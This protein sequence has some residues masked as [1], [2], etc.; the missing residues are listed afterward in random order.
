MTGPEA[1]FLRKHQRGVLATV[2]RNGRPQL[3]N[4]VYAFDGARVL[5]STTDDRAKT[6]NARRDPRVSLHVTDDS[7]RHYVVV[8]GD[9]DVTQPAQAPGDAVCRQL[10]EIYRMIAGEHPDWDEFRRAMVAERRVV[11]S[12]AVEHA[13]GTV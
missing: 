11:L 9:A 10:E 8:E 7:F 1:D 3:S 6:R 2:K 4:V 13:Y 12:F 5:I